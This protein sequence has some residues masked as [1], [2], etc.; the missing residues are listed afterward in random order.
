MSVVRLEWTSDAV[1]RRSIREVE[2]HVAG[3]GWDQPPRLY[4]LVPT[5]DLLAAE[6]QLA[7][8]LGIDA[9]RAAGSLTPVEQEDVPSERPLELVLQQIMWPPQVLGC[10]AVMERVVLP[11]AAEADLPDDAAELARVLTD[12]PL[13]EDVRIAAAATRDGRAHCAVR[14]RTHDADDAVL[15]GPTLVPGLLRLLARSLED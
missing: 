2:A 4:A 9:P 15:D 5:S 8:S 12:H 14:V 7:A 10:A 1:V 11:S 13:R 3:S 6:P